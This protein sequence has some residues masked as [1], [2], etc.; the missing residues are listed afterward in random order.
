MSLLRIGAILLALRCAIAIPLDHGLD[1]PIARSVGVSFEDDNR[2]EQ[3]FPI[4]VYTQ[5]QRRTQETMLQ[6]NSEIKNYQDQ[7]Y[8]TEIK[9]G[10]QKFLAAVDTG[11]SD[12]WIAGTGYKCNNP[13]QM[14]G[15]LFGP[16][17]NKT[18]TFS[19][20][21]APFATQYGGESAGGSMVTETVTLG[22]FTLKGQEVAIV[23]RATWKGDGMSSGLIGLGFPSNSATLSLFQEPGKNM[24][25]PIFT[26]MHRQGL[27]PPWFS[28]ALNR[29]NEG[30]GALAFGALP[31]APIRYSPTFVKAPFQKAWAMDER[32]KKLPCGSVPASLRTTPCKEVDFQAYQITLSGLSVSSQPSFASKKF[33]A[34]VDSG[35]PHITLPSDM[36][37]AFNTGW[38]P[39]AKFDRTEDGWLIECTAKP[40]TFGVNIGGSTFWIDPKDLVIPSEKGGKGALCTSAIRVAPPWGIG[41]LGASFLKNVVA[42]FDVG[43]AAEMRFAARV[44]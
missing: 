1:K 15:C 11:S 20:K 41:L 16:T 44:R 42:V 19:T 9:L 32:A 7:I 33:D 28:L 5:H 10:D 26:S 14:G 13:V 40:P 38:T 8:M 37:K 27:T 25:S 34:V 43:P 39:P 21:N 36:A 2:L 24:Y 30:P 12:T 22:N 18:S 35:T 3:E 23:N 4:S 6:A 31:A 17:Y 29:I